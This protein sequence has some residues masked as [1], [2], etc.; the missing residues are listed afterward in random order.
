[1]DQYKKDIM[2]LFRGWDEENIKKGINILT[3]KNNIDTLIFFL[4]HPSYVYGMINYDLIPFFQTNPEIWQEVSPKIPQYRML[5]IKRWLSRTIL[6]LKNPTHKSFCSLANKK[7]QNQFNDF[8]LLTLDFTEESRYACACTISGKKI[9]NGVGW[10]L[11]LESRDVGPAEIS[12]EEEWIATAY[13]PTKIIKISRLAVDGYT[14]RVW[15]EELT[16]EN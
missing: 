13:H 4:S 6:K 16:P 12:H 5:E 14:D 7:V 2:E 10:E 1:M 9:I 11:F 15:T 8:P 3:E